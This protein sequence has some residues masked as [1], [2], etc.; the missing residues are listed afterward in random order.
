[1]E[2]S[3]SPRE[4]VVR[5]PHTVMG[6]FSFNVRKRRIRRLSDF[7]QSPEAEALLDALPGLIENVLNV[8]QKSAIAFYRKIHSH[9]ASGFVRVR[10]EFLSL[11]LC[12]FK[13]R[14]LSLVKEESVENVLRAFRESLNTSL[15]EL[16]KDFHKEEFRA[17]LEER[18][19]SYGLPREPF[20]DERLFA[21]GSEIL[22]IFATH[23][24]GPLKSSTDL[25]VMHFSAQIL[26]DAVRQL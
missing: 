10:R 17:L 6:L 15:S 21:S 20:P 16:E 13:R 3:P 19:E 9:E 26:K 8:A 5:E 1:V 2:S 7:P 24:A 4:I 18:E 23:L 11:F 12:I 14:L 22:R 25:K